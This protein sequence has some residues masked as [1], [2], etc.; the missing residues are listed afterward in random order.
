MSRG[1]WV[2][3]LV[4]ALLVAFP[5]ARV[6]AEGNAAERKA[7]DA[8]VENARKAIRVELAKPQPD[9][10]E[11]EKPLEEL[12]QKARQE[13]AGVALPTDAMPEGDLRT[14]MDKAVGEKK[15]DLAAYYLDRIKL[16]NAK[17]D[18]FRPALD[19]TI[20]TIVVFLLLAVILG[21]F[22]WKPMLQGLGKREYDIHAAVKDAQT[23]REEAQRL[24]EEV[25]AERVKIEDMRREIIQKAQAD[26]QRTADEIMTKAKADVQ[27]ERERLRREL[28]NARDQAAQ[29]LWK[30]TADLAAMVSSKVI[31]RQL[32][33]EDHRRF[34]DEALADIRQA[35]NGKQTAASV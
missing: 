22:A 17:P 28:E 2:G 27:A 11:I 33:A 35:G 20:W 29:E 4:L 16:Q 24:R 26:A 32:T 14:A 15:Y 12:L 23:A 30:Q 6:R 13:E 8:A 1:V 10:E 5:P 19:L 7:E 3:G 31:R 25:Q 34:V 18:I 9:Y 21:K